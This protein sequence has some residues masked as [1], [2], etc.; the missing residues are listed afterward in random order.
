M[1]S[2]VAKRWKPVERKDL[3]KILAEL[4][5]QLSGLADEGSAAKVGGLLGAE[6]LV[7]STLYRRA[8]R[9]ELFLR[10]VRVSTAEVLAVS[11]AKLA[12]DL[13]L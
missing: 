1:A 10:L 6:V 8:D 5:L 7:A 11:R 3:Q 12:L 13:G 2:A 9:Y 4:E